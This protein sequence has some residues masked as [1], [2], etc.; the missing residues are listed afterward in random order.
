MRL[1]TEH[2]KVDN[3]LFARNKA[4]LLRK[5]LHVAGQKR[6]RWWY[7]AKVMD[8]A[9][10]RGTL[11]RAAPRDE[12]QY[13]EGIVKQM[14]RSGSGSGFRGGCGSPADLQERVHDDIARAASASPEDGPAGSSDIVSDDSSHDFD[15][16]AARIVNYGR[17]QQQQTRPRPA[18]AME[19]PRPGSAGCGSVR[20]HVH[21]SHDVAPRGGGSAGSGRSITFD[22]AG[23]GAAAATRPRS[24]TPTPG[25][26][27]PQ[28]AP[29]GA[30]PASA[31]PAPWQQ[32]HHTGRG[33]HHSTHIQRQL[34]QQQRRRPGSSL[35]ADASSQRRRA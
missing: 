30:R 6:E 22:T 35:S 2:L 15:E 31:S 32:H 21:T 17:Q 23:F 25:V 29:S 7:V 12:V 5:L 18:T 19:R 16:Q 20:R 3:E 33:N 13:Y 4:Q 14:A 10:A 9:G 11:D 26:V 28:S 24:A 8:D 1:D 34:Q 27:R